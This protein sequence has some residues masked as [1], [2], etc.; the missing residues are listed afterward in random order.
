MSRSE[1]FEAEKGEWETLIGR[2]LISFGEIELIT[3]KWLSHFP[4]DSVARSGGRLAFARRVDLILEILAGREFDEAGVEFAA[5]LR[6]AKALAETRNTIAHNPVM[7]NVYTDETMDD[8]LLEQSISNIRGDRVIDLAEM[9]EF[10]AEAGDL[11]SKMWM[12]IMKQSNGNV[13]PV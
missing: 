12:L 4:R 5:A 6:R 9:K 7:M 1:R 3:H 11:A 13:R 2:A 8:V 10:A